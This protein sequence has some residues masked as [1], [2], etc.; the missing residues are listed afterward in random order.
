[1]KIYR[2]KDTSKPIIY[3]PDINLKFISYAFVVDLD[4][5]FYFIL[6]NDYKHFEIKLKKEE[7][8]ELLDDKSSKN[9]LKSN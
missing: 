9:I 4:N 6:K 2:L 1:M 8:L 3:Y 5:H 7:S